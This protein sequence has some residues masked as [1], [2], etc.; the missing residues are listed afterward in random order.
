[1]T[2][3]LNCQIETY[4]FRRKKIYIF[5]IFH[6]SKEDLKKI[7]HCI[8]IHFNYLHFKNWIKFYITSIM[9]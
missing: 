1:M 3:I 7:A 5:Y 9:S 4:I 2:N 6:A 8:E